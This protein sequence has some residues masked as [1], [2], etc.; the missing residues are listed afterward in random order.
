MIIFLSGPI[1]NTKDYKEKFNIAED[2]IKAYDS[3]VVVL[4]P[5]KLIPEH[6]PYED[7]MEICRKLIC[8]S[9]VVY[10]LSGWEKSLGANREYGYALGCGK[11]IITQERRRNKENAKCCRKNL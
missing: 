5:T 4:N 8:I 10:M 2:V 1:S 9:D 6:L 7:Q 11:T 3:D